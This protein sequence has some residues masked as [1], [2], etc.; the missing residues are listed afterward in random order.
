MVNVVHVTVSVLF[1]SVNPVLLTFTFIPC[2]ALFLAVSQMCGLW[3]YQFFLFSLKLDGNILSLLFQTLC[4]A[5]WL[6]TARSIQRLT[7]SCTYH[8]LVILG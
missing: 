4:C 8:R 2:S 5:G 1:A 3:V 7:R 6:T